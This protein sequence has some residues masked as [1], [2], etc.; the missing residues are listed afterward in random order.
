MDHNQLINNIKEKDLNITNFGNSIYSSLWYIDNKNK[1]CITFTPRG[2]C[3]ISFKQYL[4]LVGL[5]NDGENYN[6]FIHCYRCDI[7]QKYVTYKDINDLIKQQYT[8]IKFIMNPYIRAVSIYRSLTSHNL[9]FREYLKQ[10]VN[11]EIDYFNE[12]D[13][14]HYH[15]QYI[16]GE[17]NIIT[18][19]IK[20]NE[21]EIYTIKLHDNSLYTLDVNKY[22]SC[23]HGKKTD[24]NYFCGDL[25]KDIINE[26]LPYSYKCFYDDEIKN[27]CE[28]FY[29][30]DIEKYN[31]TFD[32]F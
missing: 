7:F 20:I 22:T 26:K 17:E 11:N 25:P 18:K 16:N 30:D 23:H 27:L 9:T 6:N 31:F 5:L 24:N 14:F 29:K 12:N 2:G 32:N 4:D 21:N 19:Y 13:K 28:I 8:F 1:I 3:S 15:Q 10:L